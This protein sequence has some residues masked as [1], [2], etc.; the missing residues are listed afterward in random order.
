MFY[1]RV[2]KSMGTIKKKKFT[3]TVTPDTIT[4]KAYSFHANET[5]TKLY[6]NADHYFTISWT[7]VNPI[8]T[9]SGNAKVNISINNV[10]TLSSTH[11]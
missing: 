9:L 6:P 3:V 5:I 2:Y 4:T 10:F 8:K 1:I 11:C 7:T